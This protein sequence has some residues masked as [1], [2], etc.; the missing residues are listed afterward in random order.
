M[1]RMTSFRFTVVHDPALNA[2]FARHAGASRFAYNQCLQA[3]KGAMDAKRSDPT[4]KVPWSSFD[5]INRFNGWKRSEA[6][7]RTWA[8]DGAGVAALVGVGLA[9]RGEVCAQVFEE[10][11]VDLGRGLAAF[12]RSRAGERAGSAIGFPA[13]KRKGRTRESFRIRN[14]LT[15]GQSSICIGKGH[16]R[17]ISLPVIGLVRVIEDTR[18]LRRLLRAGSD[19]TPRARV[20]FATVSRHR[21][22][23]II[24][25]NV[26]APDLHPAM[27]HPDGNGA[28][29]GFI[30]IDRGLSAW[31]VVARTDGA[32][33]DRRQAP[34]PLVRALPKLRRAS[35]L[36]SRKQPHSRNRR[37]AEKRLN[38][39]HGRIANQRRHAIHEVTIKLVK[40]HDRI[41]MEDLAVANLVRNHHLARPIADAAWGELYRQLKYKAGWYG[42]QL[43]NAP[44]WFPS[45]KTCSNCGSVHQSLDLSQRVFRCDSSDGGCGLIID[46]DLN[47]AVNLAAWADAEHRSAAQTP[48]PQ[49][50]GR[51]TNA[52][53]G[54]GAGHR[55]AVT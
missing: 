24:A 51:D 33:L 1:T 6:A 42:S 46:R 55:T 54:T 30:G 29:H 53:G 17:S 52:C 13:F 12:S 3:V 2:V 47:A 7:G 32:E 18:R 5:L 4:V 34:R 50:G 35:R 45:S 11:A 38:R 43:L 22:H 10:A 31:L 36:A 19:G 16:P 37:K 14:K 48:D 15:R 40:T 49:A 20:W 28:T 8:V 26:E 23:W 21:A 9:W 25:V 27:R 39:I 41:C 44:R